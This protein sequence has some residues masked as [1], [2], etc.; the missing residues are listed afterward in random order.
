MVASLLVAVVLGS[1][2]QKGMETTGRAVQ[3]V[4]DELRAE[5]ELAPLVEGMEL[6]RE[7]HAMPADGQNLA[8]PLSIQRA[9]RVH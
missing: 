2:C 9:V 5:F 7:I 8:P 1:G 3:P 4:S 6:V